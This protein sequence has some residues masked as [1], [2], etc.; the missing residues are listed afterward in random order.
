VPRSPLNSVQIPA[1]ANGGRSSLSANQTTAFFLV[2]WFNSGAYS[3][4]LVAGTKHRFSGFSQPR[5]CGDDVLRTL[6][7]GG[8]PNLGG[9]PRHQ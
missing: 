3:E 2:T 8:P 9:V 5:Q 4:K 1:K 7:T 6:V